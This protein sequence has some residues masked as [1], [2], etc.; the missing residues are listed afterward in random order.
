MAR[1]D[2]RPLGRLE[3]EDWRHLALFP[4]TAVLPTTVD[5]VERLLQVP[6]WRLSHDQGREGSCVGHAVALER[7]ITNRAQLIVETGRRTTV[8]YDPL[9]VWNEA[10]RIDEWG[11]T[12]PG[13]NNGTSVRA[14]YEVVRTRGLSFVRSMRLV[15]GQPRA[16]GAK[17]ADPVHGVNA[18]R[19]AHDVDEVRTAIAN[20]LPVAIGVAWHAGFDSPKYRSGGYWLPTPAEGLGRVRGGHAVCLTGASDRRQAFRLVNSWGRDYPLAWLPYATLEQLL[21]RSGEA[22]VV[23]DR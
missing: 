9:D 13:D 6:G 7:A 14:A 23:T 5:V 20:G 21:R 18:Y 16:F 15:D 1:R 2:V 10:K 8:R 4:L 12:N 3:P 17:P 22:A 11:W 19:W